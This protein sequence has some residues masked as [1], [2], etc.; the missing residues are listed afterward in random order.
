[1]KLVRNVLSLFLVCCFLFW[2]C[3]DP[4][5]PEFELTEGLIFVDGFASTTPGASFVTISES[6]VEFGVYVVNFL[7][8][9]TVNFEN[10]ET[11]DIVQLIDTGNAYQPPT[12]F[13]VTPGEEWKLNIRLASGKNIESS[14]ERV[15]N[16]IPL[17]NIDV[18]YKPELVFREDLGGK[19][20]PGHEVS[21]GFTDPPEEGNYYYWTYRTFE[22]LDFCE[23]CFEGIF[24]DGACQPVD[25]PGRGERYFDY[26]CEVDCWRIRFQEGI[27]IFNDQF[28]NGKVTSRLPIGDLLLYTKEDMV[29]E[30]QQQSL[31]PAAYEYYKILKDII[32]NS[33]GLNAPP[34]AALIGNLVNVDDGNEYVFGRFTA[35]ATSTRSLFIERTLIPEEPLENGDPVVFEPQISCPYPP[36]CTTVAPCS[37]SKFRTSITPNGWIDN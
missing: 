6:A 22:S 34:P 3:I 35:A 20:V 26:A 18:T 29:V 14:P 12:E 24:R 37:E 23:K 15:L 9:A 33:G 31:T 19:F 30:V 10:V 11:G 28:S 17:S 25:I 2:G 16:P 32:D 7:E 27:A 13:V 36:P 1:M 4:V 21:V 8:G 5:E